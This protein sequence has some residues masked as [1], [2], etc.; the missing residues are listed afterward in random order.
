MEEWCNIKAQP[1]ANCLI[2][3]FGGHGVPMALASNS[4]RVNIEGKIY[5][6][7]GWKEFFSVIIGG[8]EVASGKPS[9]DIYLEAAK[10]LNVEPSSCVVIEDSM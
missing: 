2:K 3:H 6:H 9:P 5:F 8:D 10:K 1:G 4:P 7:Q